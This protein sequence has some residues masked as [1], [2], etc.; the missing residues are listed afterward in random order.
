[1]KMKDDNFLTGSIVALVTPMRADGSIDLPA[2]HRLLDWHLECGTDGV[3]VAGTTG[4]S[5][6]LLPDEYDALLA[7][8]VEQI[9]GRIPV[10]AGTG[11]A[12]T[13]SVV[14]ASQRAAKL[15]A[16]AVLVVAPYYNR[17]PQRGLLAHY[18]AVADA[19]PVPVVLY[20]VP[21]RTVTDLKPETAI[22]L[23]EHANIIAIKE[24][25]PDEQ[26]LRQLIDSGLPVLSGDDP[27]ALMAMQMG[28]RGVISVVANIAPEQSAAMSHA[29]LRGDHAR[30]EQINNKLES[31]VRFLN[32]ETNPI[33][34]KWLLAELGRIESRLRLP[35][36]EL[37][38]EYHAAGRTA[39]Q[40]LAEAESK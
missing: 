40:V 6:T 34:A 9:D 1:M 32:S 21:G 38:A 2:W 27:S 8:A 28:A 19:C 35:L 24:A 31:V 30:A 39:L 37:S 4:E 36:V 10:L 5:A 15:G 18:R 29:A 16:D 33:P 23:A 26:R 14:A 7:A 20:N 13:A 3:V 17:P 25:V 22:A 11:S 12:S